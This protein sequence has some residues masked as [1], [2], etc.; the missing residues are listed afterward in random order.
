MAIGNEDMGQ[1]QPGNGALVS[2]DGCYYKPLGRALGTFES[3][4]DSRLGHSTHLARGN[5]ETSVISPAMEIAG[6]RRHSVWGGGGVP[7]LG[8]AQRC[9]KV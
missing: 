8:K 4:E 1:P 6:E 9:R 3:V 7:V 5:S 2:Q